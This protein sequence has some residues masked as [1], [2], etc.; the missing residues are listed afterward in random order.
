MIKIYDFYEMLLFD[1]KALSILKI[2]VIKNRNNMVNFLI[3]CIIDISF[4]QNLLL[5]SIVHTTM[6]GFL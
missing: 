2:I 1:D 3:F 4:S 6:K 5:V